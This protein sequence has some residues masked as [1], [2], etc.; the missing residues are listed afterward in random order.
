MLRDYRPAERA[1]VYIS[2]D[3]GRTWHLGFQEDPALNSFDPAC[4]YGKRNEMFFLTIGFPGEEGWTNTF[5]LR[6]TDAG[7]TWQRMAALP[8]SVDRPYL[9]VDRS[10]GPRDGHPSRSLALPCRRDIQVSEI[11]KGACQK[12]FSGSFLGIL[13]SSL[14]LLCVV[15]AVADGR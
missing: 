8:R 2:S 6:S 14:A 10:G 9:T 15:A 11:S 3:D 12:R 4:A 1:Q 7:R 5:L 13:E